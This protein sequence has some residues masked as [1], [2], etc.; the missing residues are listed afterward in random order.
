MG[1]EKGD[2]VFLG[3][4]WGVGLAA[5]HAEMVVDRSFVYGG[6]CL[7]DKFCATHGLAVPVRGAVEG[8]FGTLGAAGVG[9]VFEGRVEVDVGCYF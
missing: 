9:W 2:L 3:L 7:G 5:L 8:Y 6:G 1:F 4:A